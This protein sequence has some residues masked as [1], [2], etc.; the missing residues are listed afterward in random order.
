MPK[1]PVKLFCTGRCFTTV[2]GDRLVVEIDP[3]AH[4]LVCTPGKSMTVDQLATYENSDEFFSEVA[5]ELAPPAP[6]PT[7][8]LVKL[9]KAGEGENAPAKAEKPATGAPSARAKAPGKVR[10]L[11]KK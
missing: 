3:D 11:P 9:E 4:I 2:D 1:P 10:A 5:P 8:P 7:G 6:Q